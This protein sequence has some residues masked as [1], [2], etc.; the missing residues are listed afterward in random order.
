MHA[1]RISSCMSLLSHPARLG[2]PNNTGRTAE[3]LWNCSLFNSPILWLL[4]HSFLSHILLSTLFSMFLF[5]AHV[6]IKHKVGYNLKLYIS[7]THII[8]RRNSFCWLIESIFCS[9]CP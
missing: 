1:T 8:G 6:H 7:F 4:P 2:H 3:Q 9:W 5:L